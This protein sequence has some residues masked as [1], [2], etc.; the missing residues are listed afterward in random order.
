MKTPAEVREL[1]AK[2]VEHVEKV[3][4]AGLGAHGWDFSRSFV[5]PTE[6]KY[7]DALNAWKCVDTPETRSTLDRAAGAYVDAW[8]RAGAAWGAA[9]RP[10]APPTGHEVTAGSRA[11]LGL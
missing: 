1:A 9:G 11:E 3:T 5:A 10:G 2:V 8:R 4:P 6:D 7:L